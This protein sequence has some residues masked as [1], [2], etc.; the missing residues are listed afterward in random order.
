[1]TYAATLIEKYRAAGLFLDA[2]L[3]LLYL[4]GNIDLN[5]VGVGHYNKLSDFKIEQMALLHR[6]VGCFKRLVTT[7]HVLTEVSN[8]VGDMHETGKQK[9]FER[10]AETL[11]IVGE[12]NIS[13][14]EVARR[15]EFQYLGLTHTV[16]AELPDRFLV[17]S[18]D[19]R[20]IN[21]LRAKGIDALKWVEVLGLST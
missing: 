21:L 13:S 12:Q 1:M 10:F 3:L 17:V 5:L 20:M 7:A 6:L 19:G 16:L 11:E 9:I 14:Y 4:V 18:N 15:P 2:N 8:L